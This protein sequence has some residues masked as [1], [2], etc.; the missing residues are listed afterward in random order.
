MRALKPLVRLLQRSLHAMLFRRLIAWAAC[1]LL[2]LVLGSLLS[3]VIGEGRV[4]RLGVFMTAVSALPVFLL[5]PPSEKR[6]TDRL[7]R[8]DEEMVFEAYLEA[9]PGPVREILQR[10]AAERAS[11]LSFRELPREPLLTGLRGLCGA[12]IVSFVLMETASL[13]IL[14]HSLT[15]SQKHSVATGSGVR[16]EEQGFSEFAT[17]DP[18]ARR[19]RRERVL[20]QK[21]K[22]GNLREK[23]ELGIPG[24]SAERTASSRRNPNTGADSSVLD[25]DS[26][27]DA[28]A[29]RKQGEGDQT[30]G[31]SSP[32]T[33]GTPGEGNRKTAEPGTSQASTRMVPTEAP[34]KERSGTPPTPGQTGQGYEH[35]ADT[36]VPS[37]LLDYRSQFESR[38]AERTGR[39]IAASGRMGFG[40]LRDFQRQYFDSFT[41]RADIGFT[42]DP[43][44]A[45]LK[46][47]WVE[48]KGGEW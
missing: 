9:E 39:H 36:K 5:W 27:T 16:I 20:E 24:G 14:G 29:K 17:E 4:V 19:T 2:L 45:L 25:K 6:L 23:P 38:Y 33:T 18:A 47:R 21:E 7:R 22:Q 31:G 28:M 12:S 43:Y 10:L 41:L 46:R 3:H 32:S 26:K 1:G 48:L 44:A 13:L 34:G 30:P 15:L 42:D 40:E 11:A 35:T 37:P 8:L